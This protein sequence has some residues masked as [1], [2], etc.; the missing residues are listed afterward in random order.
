MSSV[1][2]NAV[3]HSELPDA[4][5]EQAEEPHS[6]EILKS[7]EQR[8]LLQ[9]KQRSV[10]SHTEQLWGDRNRLQSAHSC[11]RS[12]THWLGLSKAHQNSCSTFGPACVTAQGLPETLGWGL[13][14]HPQNTKATTA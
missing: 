2:A 5:F 3:S 14:L 8:K 12:R 4:S 10:P 7:V 13:E 6:A 1:S 11:S 9:T